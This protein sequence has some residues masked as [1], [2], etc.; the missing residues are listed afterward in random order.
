VVY[1]GLI[2]FFVI[3]NQLLSKSYIKNKILIYSLLFLMLCLTTLVIIVNPMAIDMTT[4]VSVFKISMTNT[5]LDSI[6]SVKW[7]PGFVTYQW[8][9]SQITN[10]YIVFIIANVFIIFALIIIALK[11]V[12]PLESIPIIMLGYLSFFYFYS[13]LRNII[14]QGI[15]VQFVLLIIVYLYRNEYKKAIFTFPIALS[16][17][18]SSAVASILFVVKKIK[19]SI[20]TLLI[21][22]IF[23]AMLMISNMNKTFFLPLAKIIGGKLGSSIIRYSSEYQI[24]R[25]GYINR[26]DFFIFTTFWIIYGLWFLKKYLNNDCFYKWLIKSY[27]SLSI[28]YN[29]FGFIAFSDRLAAYSWSL[30]PILLMYPSTKTFL[31]YRIVFL[32]INIIISIILFFY[33]D[34]S[35]L[36]KILKVI[37]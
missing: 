7:E 29:M 18:I 3:C 27:I 25:Y 37:Y 35:S 33:F 24:E 28:L 14:R 2:V 34:V 8:L 12:I 15:A 13:F 16:F 5:W 21:L 19:L 23:S 31:R 6:M 22:Y 30:V 20:K 36:Y 17:H 32:I 4:Y 1:Y 26:I 11:K 10:S 9:L